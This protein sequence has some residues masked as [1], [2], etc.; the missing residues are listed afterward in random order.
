[1]KLISKIIVAT[2]AFLPF[3]V[4]FNLNFVPEFN[5]VLHEINVLSLLC[6]LELA[7]NINKNFQKN[8]RIPWKLHF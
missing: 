3:F 7:T 1:M 6:L 5:V 4:C 2:T 8:F